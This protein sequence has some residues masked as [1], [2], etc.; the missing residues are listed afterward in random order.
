MHYNTLSEAFAQSTQIEEVDA[1]SVYHAFEQVTDGRQ[2][3]GVRYS[4]ALVLTL[5]VLGKVTGMTTLTAI[6]E[7]V[8]W[9]ADWLRQVLP[10]TRQQFPCTATYSNVLRAVD[11]VQVT[12]LLASLLTRL[13]AERRCGTEPSRLL[14]QA[15]VRAQ[16]VQVALDGKT[17]RG[18][19]SHAAPD[20]RSQHLVAL[21]ETQTG[22][23]L[24][25]QAVPDKSNE[26]M[27]EATLLTPTQ[28]QGRIVTADARH[29]QRT[30]CADIHRFGGYYVLLAKGNQPTLQEDLRLFFV[31]PP[32]DCRDWRQARTCSKGHGRL[33]RRELVASTERE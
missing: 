32:V 10:G 3:R 25:Q 22:I 18:T 26:I 24:A 8:R 11:A 23:V 7:W 14:T 31:E 4:M 21:Y 16:P 9:R 5:I 2:A 13:E 17:L 29:T 27:L 30:C 33:E 15:E 19:L 28:V 20:Q 12:Q 1:L 6:A